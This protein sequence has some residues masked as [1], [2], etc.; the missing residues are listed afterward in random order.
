M[1]CSSSKSSSNGLSIRSIMASK[2]WINNLP[3]E[4]HHFCLQIKS[5]HFFP[6]TRLWLAAIKLNMSILNLGYQ[7]CR[8]D[9]Q[10]EVVLGTAHRKLGVEKTHL[11]L[12]RLETQTTEP[13]KR[14]RMGTIWQISFRV[15]HDR[16]TGSTLESSDTSIIGSSAL[17]FDKGMDFSDICRVILRFWWS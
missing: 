15:S 14:S 17:I 9:L 7:V 8:T 13:F 3:K 5:H 10:L 12:R 16:G 6:V 1:V 4:M 11:S 2:R